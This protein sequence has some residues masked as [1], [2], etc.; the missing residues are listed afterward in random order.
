MHSG[1]YKIWNAA[2]SE[3]FGLKMYGLKIVGVDRRMLE[4][5]KRPVSARV[6]IAAV[7]HNKGI[8]VFIIFSGSKCQ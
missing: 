2:K 3:G 6:S 7:I 8:G 4:T 1:E 5:D